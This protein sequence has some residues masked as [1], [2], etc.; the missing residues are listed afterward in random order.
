MPHSAFFKGSERVPF[1]FCMSYKIDLENTLFYYARQ[2]N[3][4]VFARQ[5][6]LSVKKADPRFHALLV[7]YNSLFFEENMA[8]LA[9]EPDYEGEDGKRFDS[10]R[11]NLP[12]FFSAEGN[13]FFLFKK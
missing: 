9:E 1:L 12:P 4:C 13:S 7:L 6:R 11:K 2:M 3:Y 8:F 10:L 5:G